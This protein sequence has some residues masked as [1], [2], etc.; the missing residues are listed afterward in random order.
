MAPE[1]KQPSEYRGDRIEWFTVRYRTLVAAGA[2][3]AV[4]VAVAAWFFF[5]R[6]APPPPPPPQSVE[7]GARFT[8]IEGSVQVKRAGTLEWVDATTAAVLRSND[9]VRTGTGSTAEIVFA[10]GDQISLRPDS[11]TTIEESSQNPVS[12]QYR[13]ALSIQSGEANFQTAP[14][15]V[16]GSTTISTPTVRT[17]AERDTT[18]NI[19]VAESGDT[20]IRIFQGSG[21]A[22]TKTGQQIQ[23]ASNQGVQVGADGTAGPKTTLPQVPILTAPPNETEV[24]YPDPSRAITLLM[25]NGVETAESYRVMVDFSRTFARPLIDRQRYENTQMELRGLD[26]GTYYWKVAAIAAEG[27]EGSFAPTSSFALLKTPPSVAKPPP[28]AV[29]TLELRGNILHVRGQ[30]AP[31]AT[32]TLNG[33]RIEV[34]PDGSFNE[35]VMYEEDATSTV[36]LRATGVSGGVAE[37]RRPIVVSD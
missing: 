8:S 14:R 10:G 2:V 25:W 3:L 27:A 6:G 31:G 28:L 29:D 4:V 15:T 11:L 18:G 22:E 33:V 30:T 26:T 34:Q 16:P 35:F 20:G 37:Q 17:T 13:V 7:T 5:L 12:R 32:V 19:L 21:Q 9:L 23:L 24:S 36:L 1:N